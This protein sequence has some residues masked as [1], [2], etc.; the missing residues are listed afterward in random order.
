VGHKGRLLL[1]LLNTHHS[2]GPKPRKA[3]GTTG[4]PPGAASN[5]TAGWSLKNCK[6]LGLGISISPSHLPIYFGA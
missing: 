2:S 3:L 1:G 4:E 5:E 6:S